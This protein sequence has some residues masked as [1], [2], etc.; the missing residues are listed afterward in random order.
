MSLLEKGWNKKGQIT[1]FI[2]IGL[3]ILSIVVFALFYIN[4]ATQDTD[5][6]PTDVPAELVPVRNYV[7]D[8]LYETSKDAFLVLGQSGGYINPEEHFAK[9]FYPT[10]AGA[11]EFSPGSERLIPYWYYLDSPS[12]CNSNCQFASNRLPIDRV[13]NGM[14]VEQMVDGYIERNIKQCLGDY[15]GLEQF[16]ITEPDE[17][18]ASI[19]I[20]EDDV[21]VNLNY[22]LDVKRGNSE[23]TIENFRIYLPLNFRKIY[24]L[25]TQITLAE[26]EINFLDYNAL[27]L[28]DAFGDI[29]SDKLPPLSA[30]TYKPGA[31]I[32]WVE[33]QVRQNI[34]EMFMSYVPLIQVE[35]TK[36]YDP[37]LGD[38]LG[39]MAASV[40]N[41]MYLGFG[42]IEEDYSN[43]D[44]DFNYLSWW[45]IYLDITPSANGLIQPESLPLS[46]VPGLNIITSIFMPQKYEFAY[47]IAYPVV[48]TIKDNNT[49]NQEGYE[50][51]FALESN[52]H[53]NLPITNE[54]GLVGLDYTSS[55][56][57][58][59]NINQ[60]NSGNISILVKD[61]STNEPIQDAMI[62][63]GLG[64]EECMIDVTDEEGRF[65]GKFPVGI[66]G[67]YV[68]AYDY[69][70]Y[71]I[72][73]GTQTG[74]EQSLV[75]EMQK[76][77]YRN[78]TVV[79]KTL[80]KAFKRGDW[81]YEGDI[82]ELDENEEA[83]LLLTRVKEKPYQP[84]V[85]VPISYSGEP[86]EVRLLPG[87]YEVQGQ[88]ISREELYIPEDERQY[89]KWPFREE[90]TIEA[91]TLSSSSSGG[92]MFN[93]SNSYWH[94]SKGN[95]DNND[96][97][98]FYVLSFNINDIPEDMRV[99]E[100]LSVMGEVAEFSSE[101]RNDLE[102]IYR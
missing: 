45:P 52:L 44:V 22:P 16:E 13:E 43:L 15:K 90:E 84:D 9:S 57:Q 4:R 26:A 3:V 54:G 63:F 31:P 79:G 56:S 55:S 87:N 30:A 35:G 69:I 71:F 88:V 85:T 75:V 42:D 48:I 49:L 11:L 77:R 101:N 65:N 1:L 47:D 34:E 23:G 102:P 64:S 32:F 2:I 61:S 20:A 72:P 94:L 41:N 5:L 19:N 82:R 27:L 81:F 50:F 58:A 95:L 91:Q 100:D 97:I 70:D 36:N 76:Y 12:S 6:E 33:S 17:I 93:E 60:R 40:V 74:K 78:V 51:K 46:G 68:R 21:V 86:V 28:I 29:N 83:V 80:T 89:G 92:V 8:C 39:D 24:N 14:S 73:F 99:V 38:G 10:E 67:L 37:N 18:T 96:E 25:A 62:S 53:N 66:G 59:C 7:E 98:V